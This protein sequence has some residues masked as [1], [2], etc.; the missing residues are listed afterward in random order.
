[1][2]RGGRRRREGEGEGG[3]GAERFLPLFHS[4]TLATN[5]AN[6]NRLLSE[7]KTIGVGLTLLVVPITIMSLSD[8]RIRLQISVIKLSDHE[9][10][11]SIGLFG[12]AI[13]KINIPSQWS[14]L[15]GGK[16]WGRESRHLPF[17]RGCLHGC[18]G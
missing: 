10:L 11:R 9:N 14:G 4:V 3:G 2:H 16:G 8:I 6:S 15:S 1:M 18:A 7:A 5:L 17:L 12:R 13:G